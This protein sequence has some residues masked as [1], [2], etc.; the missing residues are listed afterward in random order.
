MID[1]S[2]EIMQNCNSVCEII[3]QN[4]FIILVLMKELTHTLPYYLGQLWLMIVMF[5]AVRFAF[6]I[7]TDV[8]KLSPKKRTF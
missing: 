2:S 1:E 7:Q 6:E 5:W 8:T 4:T 3:V